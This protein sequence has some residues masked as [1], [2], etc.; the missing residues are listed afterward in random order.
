L[1]VHVRPSDTVVIWKLDRLG[2]SL[3]HLVELVGELAERK[4]GLQGVM[5]R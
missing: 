1:L 2:R 3:K 4:V 5:P